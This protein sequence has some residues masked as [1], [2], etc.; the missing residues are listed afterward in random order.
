M[1]SAY[2][3]GLG[4]NQP[5]SVSMNRD[6]S[7]SRGCLLRANAATSQR[8]RARHEARPGDRRRRRA[9]G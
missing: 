3:V 5:I 7:E 9:H 4:V 8:L 2:V 1:R 6:L